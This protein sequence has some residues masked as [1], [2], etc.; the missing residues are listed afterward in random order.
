VELFIELP[1]PEPDRGGPVRIFAIGDLH[2]P[3]GTG[4]SMDKFGEHWVGHAERVARTWDEVVLPEDLVLVPGD[5]SWAMRLRDAENDLAWLSARPGRKLLIRGNHDYWW[6]SIGKVRAALPSSCHAIQNDA[7][8]DP[9]GHVAVAGSRLWDVP[10]L[11]LGPIFNP[12][13]PVEPSAGNREAKD[14]ESAEKIF[15]REM[16]RLTRSLYSLPASAPVRVAMLHYPPTNPALEGTV[17]TDLLERHGVQTCV[18]GHLHNLRH[19]VVFD[20]RR[21]GIRYVLTSADFL[22][23]R[24]LEVLAV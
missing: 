10:G 16:E 13:E 11:E 24:P 9:S 19:G 12:S 5:I 1:A 21:N 14:P 23:F 4:K 8:V 6:Q 18:F 2:M 7:W 17:V 22:S 15:L 3:G 20:G